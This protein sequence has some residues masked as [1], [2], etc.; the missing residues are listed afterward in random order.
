VV[1]SRVL[2]CRFLQISKWLLDSGKWWGIEIRNWSRA[3][4]SRFWRSSRLGRQ[5]AGGTQMKCPPRDKT[6]GAQSMNV[7]CPQIIIIIS[8]QNVTKLRTDHLIMV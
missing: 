1:A 4:F 8:S 5:A 6:R 3:Q 7:A 2:Y